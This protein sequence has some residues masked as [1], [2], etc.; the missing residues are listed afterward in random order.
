MG[1]DVV[2][3][4]RE[5]VE[6]R[7]PTGD[8]QPVGELRRQHVVLDEL[9]VPQVQQ[10]VGGVLGEPLGVHFGLCLVGGDAPAEL[11]GD[12]PDG[13]PDDGRRHRAC[14]STDAELHRRPQPLDPARELLV[15]VSSV[16]L[17]PVADVGGEH[18]LEPTGV[19]HRLGEEVVGRAGGDR[20]AG[21]P[22][23]A[24]GGQRRL[25]RREVRPQGAHAGR[26]VGGEV[27]HRVEGGGV[28]LARTR[29]PL[30][31][32]TSC[33]DVTTP[34]ASGWRWL[35]VPGVMV[36]CTDGRCRPRTAATFSDTSSST[37]PRSSLAWAAPKSCT[38][39]E[40]TNI[41][42]RTAAGREMGRPRRSPRRPR[43]RR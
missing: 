8:A 11:V 37:R 10:S 17:G 41:A 33:I 6:R 43:R 29:G 7:Q 12:R 13:R 40:A 19:L 34:T 39:A 28:E 23:G 15:A 27:E 1:V 20:S 3:P 42:A 32:S 36:R 38:N 31:P 26:R 4:C 21:D 18:A 25:E 16:L 35:P 30:G 5:L 9:A 2:Q 22:R 14:R 24:S